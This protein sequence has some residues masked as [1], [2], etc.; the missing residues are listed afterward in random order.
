MAYTE[1]PF[2]FVDHSGE[3]STLTFRVEA[4]ESDG[5]N[6]AENVGPVTGKRA[7]LGTA[8]GLMTKMNE[9]MSG[10]YIPA[11]P[12]SGA[13]PA[14]GADRELALRLTYEDT[15][16][17]K[18]YRMDI[19]APVDG[20]WKPNSDELDLADVGVAAFIVVL[21]ANHIS[22]DGNPINVLYGHKVGR[23]N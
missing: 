23:R 4:I 7:V 19:P 3:K 14:E 6:W 15:V 11:T 1:L 2:T 12:G 5:S 16:T 21:E 22:Q 13:L 17:K 20:I 10:I 8:V 9:T 18:K